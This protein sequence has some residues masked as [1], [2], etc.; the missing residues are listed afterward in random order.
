MAD[1]RWIGEATA[2]AQVDFVTPAN[3]D[4]DDI[5]EILLTNDAGESYQIVFTAT[6]A[7]VQNVVE[8]LKAAADVASAAGYSPWDAVTTTEDDTKTVITAVTAGVPFSVTATETQGGGTDSQTHI[9]TSSVANS[10]PADW[11]TA[12]NWDGDA[13]PGGAGSQDVYVEGATITYGLDQS[14][15]SN[16]LDS[17]NITRSVI[18]SNGATGSAPNYLQIKAAVLEVGYHYGPGTASQLAPVNIDLGSTASTVTIHNTGTNSTATMA[19]CRIKANSASTN[20]R[21]LKGRVGIASEAGE[22]ATVSSVTVSYVSQQ[23][24]DADVFIGSGVTL[25]TLTMTGG[26]VDLRCAATT[27]DVYGGDLTTYGSGTIATIT[28][29]GGDCEANSTGTITSA[30][31]ADGTLDMTKSPASRTIITLKVDP[32]GK[33]KYDPSVITLTNKIQSITTTRKLV[34]TVTDS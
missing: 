25:T 11:G 22:T 29:Y 21:V 24:S 14:G 28:L 9:R 12:L 10:G 6:A 26:E 4:A 19:A 27:V 34:F 31:I 1:I 5:F 23:T 7:T 33:V 16:T 8:G 20:V 30:N 3:V 17:L 18:G 2:V 13:V 15:I 32:R